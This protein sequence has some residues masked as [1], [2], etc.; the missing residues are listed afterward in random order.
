MFSMLV[1]KIGDYNNANGDR[2]RELCDAIL[3]DLLKRTDRRRQL[4]SIS[5]DEATMAMK[6][7]RFNNHFLATLNESLYQ[8]ANHMVENNAIPITSDEL[9]W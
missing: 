4:G 7:A 9:D 1:T 8:V 6:L 5:D 2:I 3:A